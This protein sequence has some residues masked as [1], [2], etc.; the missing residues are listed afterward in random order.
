MIITRERPCWSALGS[1]VTVEHYTIK[2]TKYFK[3]ILWQGIV[4]MISVTTPDYGA[5]YPHHVKKK[6]QKT[7]RK[8]ITKI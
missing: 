7:M 4:F 2:E 8:K 5:K 6:A 3:K 1:R